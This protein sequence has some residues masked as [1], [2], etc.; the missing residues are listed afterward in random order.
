MGKIKTR[1]KPSFLTS[2]E[3]S[4]ISKLVSCTVVFIV[5]VGIICSADCLTVENLKFSSDCPLTVTCEAKFAQH[6]ETSGIRATWLLNGKEVNEEKFKSTEDFNGSAIYYLMLPCDISNFGNLTCQVSIDRD[7]NGVQESE[8]S[9]QILFP[10]VPKINLTKDATVNISSFA[11]LYCSANGYPAPN[12]SW[13]LNGVEIKST[14]QKLNVTHLQEGTS[15]SSKI[16]FEN[17]GRSDNGTYVCHATNKAGMESKPVILFVQTKP[18]VAVDFALGVGNGSIYLNWTLNNGNLPIRSYQIKYLK[19]GEESWQY[20][21][22]APNVSATSLVIN[23]LEPDVAYHIQIEAENMMGRSHPDKYKEAVRTLSAE[24]E[25][26]PVVDIKGSTSN[27]FTLG[28][29]APP[30][31]IRHLIGYYVSSYKDTEGGKDTIIRIP[32]AD[33][34]PVHL[35]TNLKPATMYLFK[36]KACH[37]YTGHCGNFSEPVKDKT[38][39]GKPSPPRNVKMLC[40]RNGNRYFVTVTWEAPA[41]P[42]GQLI[43][44]SVSLSGVAHYLNELNQHQRDDF[45]PMTQNVDGTKFTALFDDIPPNTNYSV[46]VKAETRIQHGQASHATCQMPPSIPD[47]ENLGGLALTRYQRAE[48]WG[49][50]TSLPKISQRKGP[51]CCYSVVV[52]KMLEGKLLTSLPEPHLLPLSTY[53]EVHRQGAGAYIAEL[54]D[55]D[56][57]PSDYVSLGDGSRIDKRNPPCKSCSVIQWPK[58][59][60]AEVQLE[61]LD[62]EDKLDRVERSS[63]RDSPSNMINLEVLSDDGALVPESNYTLFVRLFSPSIRGQVESVYSQYAAPMT[64]KPIPSYQAADRSVV[65]MVALGILC[66]LAFVLLLIVS[67]LFFLRRY[68]KHVAQSEGVEMSLS[69]SCRHLW[70]RFRDGRHLL[71]SPPSTS[72]APIPK[73]EILQAYMD[74][75][76]NADYGFQHEYELLPE[77]FADRTTRASDARE[78]MPKNRYPDIKAYDQTRVKL[79]TINGG[80][81]SEYINANFVMGYKERKKFVCAQGPMEGTVFDFWRMAWEQRVEIIVMLTNVEEYNKTKCFQYWPD[82]DPSRNASTPE[83]LYVDPVAET[84]SNGG[85]THSPSNGSTVDIQQQTVIGT[86]KSPRG[87]KTFGDI[88]VIHV[89]EKRYSEYVV[90]ELQVSRPKVGTPTD[91]ELGIMER[92]VRPVFQYHYLVW[93]DFQAP[94]HAMGI[95]RFLRRLNEDYSTDRGPILIHCSAGVGRTGTLVAIDHLIQQI[96]EE[97]SISVLNTVCDLRHQRNFLVQSLRQYIFVYR[98]LMEWVQFGNTEIAV[99][100][101]QNALINLRM[102]T[103]GRTKSLLEEEFDRLEQPFDDRKPMSVASSEENRAKNRYE[104]AIPFD[105]NRVIL[106]PVAGRDYST[107]INASFIEGYDNSE[108]FILT[109]DPMDSTQR[110]FWRMVLEHNIVV[111]VMLSEMGDASDSSCCPQYWPDDDQEV[112][113]DHIVVKHV[114]TVTLPGYIQ[115]DFIVRSS[116]TREEIR[117]TQ[118]Q[119]L[120]WG[121]CTNGLEDDTVP[122]PQQTSHFVTVATETIAARARQLQPGSACIH[123]STGN[124]RSS[125][126]AALCIL[127]EQAKTEEYVDVFSTVRKLRS[128]RTRMVE[129]PMQYAFL[130]DALANYL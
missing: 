94:E 130:Y 21:R 51:I 110:D 129:Y 89:K 108:S 101:F 66:G 10:V 93:K 42:N 50:R 107:Y 73:Q 111:I 119:Y 95:L 63:S 12:I 72:A 29:T 39:D 92:E 71:V 125:I 57:L 53:E 62:D 88:R 80:T 90:R 9:V 19:D 60:E 99:A 74:R 30:E 68:S 55:Y 48:R 27:S 17:V 8:K 3:S 123:C 122:A 32:A 49:L 46:Q 56:R 109:Q 15:V 58:V 124:I 2:D 83:P 4:G 6:H 28:W 11:S 85:T 37:R 70:S 7:Q 102:K 115:R 54:F 26:T 87:D 75:H 104:S 45:G 59:S 118:I 97:G 112:T 127:I 22:I 76:Q 33:G 113:H 117:T 24:A 86:L 82:P 38:I 65:L 5:I 64:P 18:E 121:R 105:R 16:E 25:Y 43:H 14:S 77:R 78:N 41:H 69:S 1:M 13:T 36:V 79:N 100:S 106:T 20:S 34:S 44:F 52:V 128:Q 47:K 126:M 84:Q 91:P 67:S 120:G 103:E 96:E 61:E 98:T 35:F 23:D 31:E 40:D 81:H 114:S 116:K